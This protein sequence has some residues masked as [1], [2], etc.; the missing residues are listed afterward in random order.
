MAE[1]EPYLL[2][3]NKGCGQKFKQ[4]E[5]TET[6]CRFHPGDHYFH[7][8]YKGWTCCNRKTVDFTEFLNMQG[9]A[10]SFHS[11]D[12]PVEPEKKKE[13]IDDILIPE[14]S[15]PIYKPMDRPS[16]DSPMVDFF[17]LVNGLSMAPR[18]LNCFYF[19]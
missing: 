12:K 3:Y 9:C 16:A 5:N 11:N 15:R 13:V 14:P 17:F 2:C 1:E 7:D 4:S 19:Y 6:S 10:Y 18:L 8:A